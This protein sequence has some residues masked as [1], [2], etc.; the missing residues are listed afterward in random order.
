MKKTIRLTN[1]MNKKDLP[2]NIVNISKLNSLELS[3]NNII[4]C[5]PEMLYF[6]HIS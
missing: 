5:I 1:N 4:P 2:M 6:G 3:I